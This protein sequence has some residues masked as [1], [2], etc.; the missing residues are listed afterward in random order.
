MTAHSVNATTQWSLLKGHSDGGGTEPTARWPQTQSQC[1]VAIKSQ[2]AR[3]GLPQ[4]VVGPRAHWTALCRAQRW[5][6][7]SQARS[8]LGEL[9][10]PREGLWPPRAFLHPAARD[11]SSAE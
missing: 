10:A 6:Q 7:A 5:T 11:S 9:R 8:A 4:G 3:R 2:Q 1:L